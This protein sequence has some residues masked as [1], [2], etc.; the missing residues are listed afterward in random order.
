M[1]KGWFL[2]ADRC[3]AMSSAPN[4]QLSPMAKG[5]AC[6]TDAANAS[7]VCPDK[8]RPDSVRVVETMTGTLIPQAHMACRA[9]NIAALAFKVSNA[10]SIINRST[11]PFIRAWA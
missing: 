1:A 5:S 6:D 4:P 10:V 11:P 2:N 8:V 7:G 9:A 3:L